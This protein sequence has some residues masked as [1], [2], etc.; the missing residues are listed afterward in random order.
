MKRPAPADQQP[1]YEPAEICRLARD[2]RNRLKNT[3]QRG[4]KPQ[5]RV[6]ATQGQRACVRKHQD[7]TNCVNVPTEQQERASHKSRHQR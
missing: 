2:D 5:R 7:Q 1:L 4:A 6:E 3:D